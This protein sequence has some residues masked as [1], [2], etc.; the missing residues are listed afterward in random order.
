MRRMAP[1]VF[2]P[3]C[4]E[5][6]EG[7]RRLFLCD[8]HANRLREDTLVIW[9]IAGLFAF[10]IMATVVLSL[11]SIRS[12]LGPHSIEPPSISPAETTSL[13]FPAD[14]RFA[15]NR[16]AQIVVRLSV[17]TQGRPSQARVLESSGD[18]LLDRFA[19]ETILG[20][21]WVPGRVG[22]IPQ[23]MEVELPLNFSP[24]GW[25]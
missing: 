11:L 20:W 17:D 21:R 4:P 2:D 13:R 8:W 5:C 24:P 6:N 14:A 25:R 1:P 7:S 3:L 22:G 19:V 9:L 18:S 23:D 15:I 16:P 12:R 10:I